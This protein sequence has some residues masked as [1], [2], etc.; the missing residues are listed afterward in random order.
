MNVLEAYQ[1]ALDKITELENS[2]IEV[3]MKKTGKSLE[4]SPDSKYD[5][6]DR[7]PRD[8]YLHVSFVPKSEDAWDAVFAAGMELAKKG[9]SFDTGAGGGERDW[10][11]DWSFNGPDTKPVFVEPYEGS[12]EE[13]GL[14]PEASEN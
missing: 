11:L 1:I 10:E 14:T 6:P 8:L 2:G 4:E 13:I 3:K 12:S 5:L 9:I 7:L